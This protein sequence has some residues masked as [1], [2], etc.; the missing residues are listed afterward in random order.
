MSKGG[1]TYG[2]YLALGPFERGLLRAQ[3][4]RWIADMK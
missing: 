1:M 4:K 3:V 2:E